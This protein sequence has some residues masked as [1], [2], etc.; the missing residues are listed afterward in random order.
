MTQQSVSELSQIQRQQALCLGNMCLWNWHVPSGELVIEQ[1]SAGAAEGHD[2][3]VVSRLLNIE[4]FIDAQDVDRFF[5][6]ALS[7]SRANRSFMLETQVQVEPNRWEAV[8]ITGQ[9]VER[10]ADGEPV[11]I[12]AYHQHNEAR[13]F[14]KPVLASEPMYQMILTNISD[15][16]LI[17]DRAGSFKFICPNISVIFGYTETEIQAFENIQNLFGSRILNDVPTDLGQ[18]LTNIEMTI[19]DKAGQRHTLLINIKIVPLWEKSVLFTCRDITARKQAEEAYRRSEAKYGLIVNTAHEG[20]WQLDND[21]RVTYVNPHMA[22][23][24]GYTADELLGHQLHEFID[25]EFQ[26]R[27]TQLV[28]KRRQAGMIQSEVKYRRKDGT[29]L[30]AL[31]VSSNLFDDTGQYIGSISF[32]TDITDRK[33]VEEALHQ[34][35]RDMQAINEELQRQLKENVFAKQALAESEAE[36]AALINNVE[37]SIFSIDNSRCLVTFNT[38]FNGRAK[39]RL[40]F[41]L[42]K[43]LKFDDYFPDVY[44]SQYSPLFDRV[45]AGE[46][47]VA[48][49]VISV[50]EQDIEVYNEVTCNPL[51][52]AAGEVVGAAIYVHD[53]TQSKKAELAI[54]ASETRFRRVV[55]NVPL[56]F[57]IYDLEQDQL[58]Y[59]N[60]IA[61]MIFLAVTGN[62]QLA[63]ARSGWFAHIVPE[64]LAVIGDI[65]HQPLRLLEGTREY[66]IKILSGEIR[67]VRHIAFPI[68]ERAGEIQQ[69]AS[70]IE[71]ITTRKRIEENLK[72]NEWL[73]SNILSNLPIGVG[74]YA[75]DGRTLSINAY[76]AEYYGQQVA[77]LIGANIRDVV[78]DEQFEIWTRFR[79]SALDAGHPVHYQENG[80]MRGVPVT[81]LVGCFPLLDTNGEIFAIGQTMVDITAQ[82]QIEA[83]LRELSQQIVEAQEK[84]RRHIAR[85][86][87]DEVG[88]SLTGVLLLL[89]KLERMSQGIDSATVLQIQNVIRQLMSQIRELSHNLHPPI[90]DKHGLINALEWYCNHYT[91]QTGIEVA[92]KFTGLKDLLPADVALT[93]YR[94]VQEAM[95]NVARYAQVKDVE[96]YISVGKKRVKLIISDQGIGFDVQTVTAKNT[97]G[98]SGMGERI[99]LLRGK[100]KINSAPGVGTTINVEIPLA[101]QR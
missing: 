57:H 44:L 1:Y 41:E 101:D 94:V 67:Y 29:A 91:G 90:L 47:F 75:L 45:L 58:V 65:E 40:G 30:W 23:M 80:I 36:L 32:I 55:E 7:A 99:A 48:P 93:C 53:V 42:F 49:T 38:A 27:V 33:N 71:D 9:A 20:I 56:S 64:D 43:G 24:I 68:A 13:Q 89:N 6:S 37:D 86:L 28:A 46:S 83:Q 39:A 10:N 4:N 14:S 8:N 82:K 34:Q 5:E 87:H 88:Q 78:N 73:L 60:S 22:A 18:E 69:I 84:E 61:K 79:A 35:T 15:T 85:E 96:V 66:R 59:L 81:L 76:C 11:R 31:V 72:Q 50:P 100:I 97:F 62:T 17:T 77:S 98:L 52:S 54:R 92:F 51:R 21:L 3:K 16:V 74:V 95:T 26:Q 19:S 63:T 12:A 70:F 25:P 2:S